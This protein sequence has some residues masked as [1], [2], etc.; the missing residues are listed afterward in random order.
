MK[1]LHL[2]F[3]LVLVVLASCAILPVKE[4][5]A[6]GFMMSGDDCIPI[7]RDAGGD[8]GRDMAQSDLGVDEGTPDAG[9]CGMPC[10][11]ATPVC[12]EG[13]GECVECT[14]G[15]TAACSGATPVCD[16]ATSEC[17]ACLANSDCTTAGASECAL[18]THTCVG[19]TADAACAGRAGTTACDP[20]RGECV[21]CT[22]TNRTACGANVCD[23][24]ART[25]ATS[26][27][28]SANLCENCV[29]DVQCQAGQVCVAMSGGTPT[30]VLGHYCL[31]REAATEVGAPNGACSRTRPYA[32][33]AE[34]SA[35][36]AGMVR[37]CEP[38]IASCD[39][40]VDF[41]SPTATCTPAAPAVANATCG[42]TDVDD[43]YCQFFD[44]ASN[45]CTV[46]CTT[47]EDCPDA[48]GTACY[49]CVGNY[50]AFSTG[51]ESGGG[52]I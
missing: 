45:R 12:N 14:A 10:T 41:S 22:G 2:L 34:R 20:T 28:G 44:V 43:G 46:G 27:V 26:A 13:T 32:Q 52:C 33:G 8:G 35:L 16:T 23:V 29:S 18:A 24:A 3:P 11:G 9:P 38:R 50:C 31:W 42:A 49:R 4:E 5:C 21:Q 36:E 1:P 17:V 40:L 48:P 19:C 47:F 25:C 37:V 15:A 7:V 30:R 39:A 51:V 6:S